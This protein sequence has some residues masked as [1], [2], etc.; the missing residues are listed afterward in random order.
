MKK[1]FIITAIAVTA[2]S[3]TSC[4]KNYTCTCVY[5]GSNAGTTKTTIKAYKRNDARETCD[6]VHAGAQL[7]GGAC[8]LE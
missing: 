5:P 6:K 4:E 1:L 8:A 2:I 3:L 7:N